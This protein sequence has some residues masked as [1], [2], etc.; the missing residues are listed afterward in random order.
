M[1]AYA[2]RWANGSVSICSARTKREAAELFDEYAEVRQ[3]SLITLKSRLMVTLRID[4]NFQRT[5]DQSDLPLGELLE[6]ELLQRC[7][8]RLDEAC[9]TIMR[10]GED[11]LVPSEASRE[12]LKAALAKDVSE[13]TGSHTKNEP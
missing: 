1:S 10:N 9:K 13:A 3:A 7:Y 6:T 11:P 8:P 2:Y 12:L 4:S 5:L